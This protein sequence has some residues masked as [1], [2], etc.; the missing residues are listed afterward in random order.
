MSLHI[1]A[2][3]SI[4]TRWLEAYL[5]EVVKVG[6]CFRGSFWCVIQVGLL[7][8]RSDVGCCSISLRKYSLACIAYVD[9]D[10]CN[11]CLSSW[12]RPNL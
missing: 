8:V 1:S 6:L 2:E 10:L 4:Y 9:L 7:R 12:P 3:G 11:S 5:S